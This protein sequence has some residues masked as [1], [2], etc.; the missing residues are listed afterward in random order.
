MGSF[1]AADPGFGS[2]PAGASGGGGFAAL[3]NSFGGESIP[4]SQ[5]PLL[6][7]SGGATQ[8]GGW[9][10]APQA[11]VNDALGRQTNIVIE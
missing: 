9:R 4:T 6:E 11:N 10:G 7:E 3:F 2:Y 1:P 8:L 5:Y